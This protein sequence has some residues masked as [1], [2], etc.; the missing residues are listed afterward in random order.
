MPDEVHLGGMSANKTKF[1][2]EME[3][4]EKLEQEHFKRISF[5]KQ[6]MKDMRRKEKEAMNERLE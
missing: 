6:E 1:I 2:R 5:S 4:L 3:T